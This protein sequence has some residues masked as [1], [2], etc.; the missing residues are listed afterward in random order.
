[1]VDRRTALTVGVLAFLFVALHLP[2]LPRSLE[3]VD[4]INFALGIRDFDVARH[5]PHPPGYPLF[6]VAA[7]AAHV[8]I[9]PEARALATV[10]VVAGA[11]SILALVVLFSGL[12][13]GSSGS[14]ARDVPI[15]AAVLAATAPLFWV[16][17]VRP[18]S[19][20]TGLAAA[21]GVQA[22]TL[23]ATA[24]ACGT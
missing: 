20:V 2:F 12:T 4:S 3:D 13:T 6:I 24:P 17:A 11:L 15:T 1:M 14:A 5:Q 10:N 18:L 9:R 8:L 21:L 19:D 23:A 7:K 22:I 16:T